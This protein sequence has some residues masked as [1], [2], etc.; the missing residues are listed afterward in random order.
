MAEF[1]TFKGTWPWP[2]IR[3]YCIP[4]ATLVDLNLHI[5]FH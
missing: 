4:Y 5:K 2:W 3:S 1:P